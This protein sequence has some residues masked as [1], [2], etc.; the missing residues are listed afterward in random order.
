M[1]AIESLKLSEW[2]SE[3]RNA[4]FAA[5]EAEEAAG[6]LLHE[7]QYK[8]AAIFQTFEIGKQTVRI[9]LVGDARAAIIEML[10][11]RYNDAGAHT[12]WTKD[13]FFIALTE[14]EHE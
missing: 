4:Y 12:A 6:Y 8:Q 5:K 2:G 11:G 13:Q 3:A 10:R 9:P 7:A 1:S 14:E